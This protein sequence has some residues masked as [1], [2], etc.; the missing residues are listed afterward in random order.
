MLTK[1]SFQISC[2]MGVSPVEYSVYLY[3]PTYTKSGL[4]TPFILQTAQAVF[5][6]VG[7]T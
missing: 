5:V 6:C 7:A 1:Q 3:P 2:G 4:T